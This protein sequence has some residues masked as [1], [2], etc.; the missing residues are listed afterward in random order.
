MNKITAYIMVY[1]LV[2]ILILMELWGAVSITSW[3]IRGLRIGEI[4]STNITPYFRFFAVSL[5][6]L[7]FIIK[8]GGRLIDMAGNYKAAD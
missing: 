2:G 5:G 6:L 1:F 4:N 7:T 8:F 3:V